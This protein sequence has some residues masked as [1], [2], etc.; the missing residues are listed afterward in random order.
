MAVLGLCR[1]QLHVP[2]SVCNPHLAACV[3]SPAGFFLFLVL[4]YYFYYHPPTP[5]AV[6]ADHLDGLWH[7]L[8]ADL[9]VP[10]RVVSTHAVVVG[11]CAREGMQLVMQLHEVAVLLVGWH[12][13]SRALKFGVVAPV[14]CLC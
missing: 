14:P 7:E 10:N 3:I 5:L 11:W 1:W 4:A 12:I 13:D 9:Q 2:V 6:T 8:S